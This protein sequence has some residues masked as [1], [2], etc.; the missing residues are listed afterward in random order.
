MFLSYEQLYENQ[1][2]VCI[3]MPCYGQWQTKETVCRHTGFCVV[4]VGG[5]CMLSVCV[6]FD[7][8]CG[9]HMGGGE[10]CAVWVAVYKKIQLVSPPYM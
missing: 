7:V 1:F 5:C 6:E 2:D 9:P 8:R 4:M 10:G 3:Y